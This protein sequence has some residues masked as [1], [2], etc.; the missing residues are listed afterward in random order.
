MALL[1]S[2]PAICAAQQNDPDGDGMLNPTAEAPAFG[3]YVDYAQYPQKTDVPTI[4]I[5]TDEPLEITAQMV[6][7][8]EYYTANIVIVDANGK[9]K[10]RNEA[11]TFRGRGNATWNSNSKKKAWRLKFPAKTSLLSEWDMGNGVEVKNYA[12]A[13]SWTLLSNVYDKSLLRNALSSELGKRAGLS[14]NPAYRFVDLVINGNYLGTY[15]V[16]DHIQVDKKRVAVN[17]NTGWFMEFSKDG[18]K[19][20][21]F[22][23]TK[24]L[25][26]NIATSVKN[27]GTDIVT[28]NGETTDPQYAPMKEWMSS[29]LTSLVNGE[30]ESW[31]SQTD[32]PSL[33]GWLMVEDLA[34][35]Y[36]G[37]MANVYT[38]K[39]ADDTQLKW[40]PLWDLDLAYGCYQSLAN[41]HFWNAQ[42]EG[43]GSLIGK[44]F[45]DPY[46]V[47]AYY[48]KWTEFQNDGEGLEEFVNSTVSRL[49]ETLAQ[50]Q[51]LNYNPGNDSF[52]QYDAAWSISSNVSWI[53]N[54]VSSYDAAVTAV[55]EYVKNRIP[56]LEQEYTTMYTNLGCA[57]L[58]NE[59]PGDEDGTDDG[60]ETDDNDS[61]EYIYIKEYSETN[62]HIPNSC[63]NKGAE[64]IDILFE[65]T[66]QFWASIGFGNNAWSKDIEIH[67]L[68][69]EAQYSISITDASQI[70]NV[71]ENGMQVN[72][73]NDARTLKVT[74]T[75]NMPEK[76]ENDTGSSEPENEPH[77]QLT[78]LPTIYLSAETIGDEWT[79]A[80]VEVFD[81]E[82][83]LGQG[84]TWT[85]EG[86][87]K[88]GNPIVSVQFQGSGSEGTKNSYRLKFNDK[89][90]LMPSGEF[91]QWVLLANDDDPS[92]MRNAL[93]KKMGDALGLPFTPGYQFVDL[94]FNEEY[95]GTYQVT[96][97]IK[98]EAGR[99]MVTGGN[100]E[101]DWHVRFNDKSEFDEDKPDYS[102]AGTENMPYI[103]PKNPDPKDDVTTWDASLKNEM[104]TYFS[105]IFAKTDGHY[106]AFADNVD[107]QQ[108]VQWYIA[109][110]VLG[111]YKGF[112]SIEA[113]R[114]IKE[115]AADQKLHIG[116]L[117]DSE[118][119]LGN[120]GE[121]EAID[122]SDLETAD[123]YNGLMTNYAAY[124]MMKDLFKD[125]W[126]QP[127][128]ARAINNL[129]KKKQEALLSSL[130]ATAKEL[131]GIL[132]DS[133]TK[134]LEK[135]ESSLEGRESYDD[136]VAEISRYLDTRFAYLTKKFD[137]LACQALPDIE[138]MLNIILG[139]TTEDS[140]AYD[141]N[142]DGKV[143]VDDLVILINATMAEQ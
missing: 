133:Q 111:V 119:S 115:T 82:E 94:Y 126:S 83:T 59:N 96:D 42:N 134:N 108:L 1:C 123:S 30:Y 61:H 23:Y 12:D 25:W 16:S 80:A 15:Q 112:S 106:T 70:L 48:E 66:Q 100:K 27:P 63:F 138:T 67:W 38:Y 98:V 122:M 81:Q 54:G 28:A 137:S 65:N 120:P 89:I 101:L 43:V 33:I 22:F 92:L 57:N 143:T 32:L 2:Y 102:I 68:S 85:K 19:E 86:L 31:R 29:Y 58:K 139:H 97:R 135:W 114:S 64:S 129:W 130:K 128:F 127:W 62:F 110:E 10:Q 50:T 18:M 26:S 5:T 51:A 8:E 37:A 91:K 75:N 55:K 41:T 60:I 88:K 72:Y 113:Y 53:N 104:S 46:F 69:T 116:V 13:K 45:E 99:A 20:D 56:W 3:A 107:H 125:L 141:M 136:A 14:F 9:M 79:Q 44:M 49:A 7:T 140:E 17:S 35:N 11:V 74:I 21:P 117:W 73:G 132:E 105:G 6:K 109:Q 36:D 118:K 40:G 24:A 131:K 142:E 76:P 71:A 95:M 47:K 90:G 77:A 39:E 87:S 52:H 78:N 84:T 103:I 121:A 34:G 93:A 124:G 4:Y